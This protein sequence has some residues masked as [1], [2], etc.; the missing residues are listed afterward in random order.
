LA[1]FCCNL[2][3]AHLLC[4]ILAVWLQLLINMLHV[5]PSYHAVYRVFVLWWEEGVLAK[6]MNANVSSYFFLL[7]THFEKMA[8]S[9]WQGLVSSFSSSLVAI[10]M[11]L[12]QL[13]VH[14]RMNKMSIDCTPRSKL[15]WRLQYAPS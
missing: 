6:K 12:R 10:Y 11:K 8:K 3:M 5:V 2:M 4:R 14:L 9:S 7:G 1:I 13:L 15:Q